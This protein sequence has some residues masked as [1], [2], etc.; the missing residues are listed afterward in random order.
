MQLENFQLQLA[1]LAIHMFNKASKDI[2]LF[3][4][5]WRTHLL[6]DVFL[7]KCLFGSFIQAQQFQFQCLNFVLLK[8]ELWGWDYLDIVLK[9]DKCINK[10]NYGRILKYARLAFFFC[11]QL[12]QQNSLISQGLPF[13][14]L[15][16]KQMPHWFNIFQD[17]R[18]PILQLFRNVSSHLLF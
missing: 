5:I 12:Q 13:T 18:S 15:V 1:N 4:K 8:S 11:W 2:F 3:S 10:L 7:R 14:I 9:N 16:N 6:L 17:R